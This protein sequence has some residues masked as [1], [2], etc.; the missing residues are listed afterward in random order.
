MDNREFDRRVR[1][2]MEGHSEMPHSSS[3]DLIEASLIKKRRTK[4]LYIRKRVVA[5]V[6][7]A[8]SLAL[9]L[10]IN[11]ID[12]VTENSPIKQ[13]SLQVVSQV[14]SDKTQPQGREGIIISESIAKEEIK[15]N[16]TESRVVASRGIDNIDINNIRVDNIEVE[17]KE[18]ISPIEP[19]SRETSQIKERKPVR[20]MFDDSKRRARKSTMLAFSTNVSPS[21][22]SNSVSLMA[23]RQEQGGYQMVDA[24]VSTIQKATVPQEVISNTK[25]LMPVSFGVQIQFPLGS[26]FAVGTGINYTLLFS[27]YDNLSRSE[28]RETQQTLHYLG[29]PLNLYYNLLSNQNLRLYLSGGI[30]LDKGLYANYKVFENGVRKSYGEPIEGVQW[31]AMAG[32]GAEFRVNDVAGFYFDPAIAYF[33]DNKQPMSIRTSQPLQFKF[34]LGLRFRM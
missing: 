16:N 32:L 27:H 34:E 2:M 15:S 28:T 13:E 31:S 23:V 30:N 10:L 26:K 11:G 5:T 24:V 1:E 18:E 6:A 12:T 4:I 33:F 7:V 14:N 8:A 9:L 21:T 3:W 29:V 22:S 17:A 19:E 25:F 20:P